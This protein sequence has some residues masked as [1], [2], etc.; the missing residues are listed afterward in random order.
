M[1]LTINYRGPLSSC[2]YTC[3]YCPFGKEWEAPDVLQADREGLARFVAWAE[4]W[5]QGSL[6]ILFTPWGEALVRS[7][8][9]DALVRLSGFGSVGQVAAQTNLSM[10]LGWLEDADRD[11]LALWTTWHPTQVPMERFLAQCARLDAMG[12]R[13]S[14]GVV[15]LHE[16]LDAIE[17]L[18]AALPDSVYLWVNAFQRV[19]DYYTAEQRAR[20]LAVDAHFGTNRP[21]ASQGAAVLGRRDPHHGRW[22][23]RRAQVS[24]R[25]RRARQPLRRRTGIRAPATDLPQRELPLPHRLHPSSAPWPL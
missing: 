16:H 3:T 20:I 9:R 12:I 21:H 19:V 24:L 10:P 4:A 14:V 13:Y 23:G 2:N 22:E 8:Y 18:R 15:G 11:T 6:H 17:A 25:G 5:E 1:R 7:W